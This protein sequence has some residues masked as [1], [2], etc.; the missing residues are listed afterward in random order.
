MKVL[1]RVLVAGAAAGCIIGSTAGAAFAN[2][3]YPLL[4][5]G[6]AAPQGIAQWIRMGGADASYVVMSDLAR[7]YNTAPGCLVQVPVGSTQ[8]YDG[9]CA[10]QDPN[11]AGV[12]VVYEN[13]GASNASDDGNPEH[14]VAFNY[15]PIGAAGG[16]TQITNEPAAGYQY[17]EVAR[18]SR[19]R[20]ASDNANLRFFAFAIDSIPWVH[21]ASGSGDPSFGVN[22]L[23]I[24]R[25]KNAFNDCSANASS[26]QVDLVANGGNGNGVADWG[27]LGG[28]TGQPI[29]T[30]STPATAA[31]RTAFEGF[32][33][34]GVNSTNCI[35]DQYKDGQLANGER[36]ILQN[37]ASP[38]IDTGN[39]PKNLNCQELSATSSCEKNSLWFYDA[40][41]WIQNNPGSTIGQPGSFDGSIL[42]SVTVAGS[43]VAPTQA[44]VVSG[45]YPLWRYLY[46]AIR[47]SFPAENASNAARNFVAAQGFLCKDDG[48]H[49]T[50]NKLPVN[51]FTKHNYRTDIENTIIADGFYPIPWG[52][53]GGPAAGTNSYCRVS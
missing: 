43:P 1:K 28:V 12:Q 48:T 46:N 31:T 22:S 8:Q 26:P 20:K 3:P 15:A 36:V 53:A 50:A 32:L 9:S 5:S 11:T 44:N 27:D 52:D 21:W 2:Q 17:L 13:D 40:G 47:Y 37:D 18:V 49:G 6:G 38:I 30:W 16:L 7:L 25:L 35:P 4:T 45:A 42:G 51:P 24:A 41:R 14:D 23:T 10:D 34:S 29:L 39:T 33:G 19:A